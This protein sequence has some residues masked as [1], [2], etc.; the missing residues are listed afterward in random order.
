MPNDVKESLE[1]WCNRNNAELLSEWDYEKN[2]EKPSEVSCWSHKKAW[3]KCK[4]GHSWTA[5]IK[6]RSMSGNGCPYCSGFYAWPGE[7][8]LETLYPEVAKTWHPTK[9]GDL[10]PSQV[11][12]GSNKTV[13]W[14]CKKGHEWKATVNRRAIDGIGCPYCRGKLLT[15]YNDLQTLSPEI[16]KEWHPTKNG[17]L[18]PDKVR[19]IDQ[20]KVWWL[21][22]CGHEFYT[23]IYQRTKHGRGCPYCS[24]RILS[25]FND[26]QTKYPELAKEWHPTKN[27]SIKPS[28]VGPGDNRKF[29]WLGKC[30]H[31]WKAAV[32]NRRGQGSGCPYCSGRTVLPG[33]NDIQTTNP[34]LLKEWH[35]TK[36]GDLKPTDVTRGSGK[37]VWWICEKGHEWKA[38]VH[39]RLRNGCPYCCNRLFK[40]GYNDIATVRPDFAKEWHPTKNNTTP[41]QVS[42]TSRTEYWWL[43]PC[44]HEWKKTPIARYHYNPGC[45]VCQS[46]SMTSFNEQA[47]YLFVKEQFPDSI[48]CYRPDYM[49]KKELDIFI[50]SLRLAIEYDGDTFH[51]KVK[52]DEEKAILCRD[53]NINL[54]RVREPKCPP[55]PYYITCFKVSTIKEEAVIEFLTYLEQYLREKYDLNVVFNKDIDNNRHRIYEQTIKSKKE[56]SIASIKPN[57]SKM[58]H[59]TKNGFLKPDM[60]YYSSEKTFWWLGPC[61]HEWTGV[62]GYYDDDAV[63]PYC[64]GV[65]VLEG[66]N[67]LATVRPDIAKEWHPTKNGGLKPNEVTSRS[68]RNIWWMCDK[69]HE[70]QRT[71]SGRVSNNSGCPVCSNQRLCVGYNDLLSQYPEIAKEWHPVLNGELQPNEVKA[72]SKLK[73]WWMCDKGH[74]WEV[75]PLVRTVNNTSCPICARSAKRNKKPFTVTNPELMKEWHPTK[76]ANL[77]PSDY[78]IGSNKKVWWMCEKGHEWEASLHNRG[79]DR[80]CPICA[81]KIIVPGYN[82]LLSQY[83]EVGRQWH[84]TKNGELRADQVSP[85]SKIKRWWICDKGHEWCAQINSRTKMGTGC[86]ICDKER[87]MTKYHN[88]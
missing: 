70:W 85:G 23:Q 51:K 24:R 12:P 46:E 33:F 86:P 72:T 11:G 7:S 49:K 3:W 56:R 65:R 1:S 63:C 5:T 16:A 29:W 58:W 54:I 34:E 62:P 25:G 26:F 47:I 88:S 20:I 59:P 35:P 10:K 84:P 36:N 28:D 43:S 18:T 32:N 48:S 17:D 66:F 55:L 57:L 22:P 53:N 81:G 74:E 4:N 80:G 14:M 82:D 64:S 52:R 38:S 9:N 79:R 41:D 19:N 39:A 2:T 27:G 6:N 50:P 42:I 45:P 71:I 87:R 60:V 61:G 69:G 40:P 15:G 30:G 21:G 76:N 75:S 83:P 77:R 13:W 37:K 8:D 73:I 78:T 31:E 44:G 68:N 67:D